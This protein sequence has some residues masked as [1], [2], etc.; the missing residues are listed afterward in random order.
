M[1]QRAWA[2]NDSRVSRA[3]PQRLLRSRKLQLTL[4]IRVHCQVP[5][6]SLRPLVVMTYAVTG[7]T[8]PSLEGCCFPGSFHKVAKY[9]PSARAMP[10]IEREPLAQ[11]L[12]A[13]SRR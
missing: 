1:S 8:L 2:R 11:K 6:D 3:G 4:H 10:E 5:S 12:A 7:S 13:R 9:S